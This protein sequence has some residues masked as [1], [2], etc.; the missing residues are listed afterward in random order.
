MLPID[1]NAHGATQSSYMQDKT[2]RCKRGSQVTQRHKNAIPCRIDRTGTI[3]LS[4][5]LPQDSYKVHQR[6]TLATF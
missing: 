6:E 5:T 1:N 2:K 4:L 3:G